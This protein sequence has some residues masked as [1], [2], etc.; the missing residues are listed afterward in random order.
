MKNKIIILH[1]KFHQRL[2]IA[3]EIV[4]NL[5]PFEEITLR[6]PVDPSVKFAE[7]P[8]IVVAVR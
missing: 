2:L 1:V 3:T 6:V 8:E 5:D 4:E 7:I